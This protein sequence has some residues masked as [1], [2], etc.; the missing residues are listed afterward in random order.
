MAVRSLLWTSFSVGYRE[1]KRMLELRYFQQ[2]N[3]KK[4]FSKKKIKKQIFPKYFFYFQHTIH[5]LPFRLPIIITQHFF[6]VPQ[7]KL[8]DRVTAFIKIIIV[9]TSNHTQMHQV[10]VVFLK[11]HARHV[12][13]HLIPFRRLFFDQT[14]SHT[15]FQHDFHRFFKNEFSVWIKKA[16]KLMEC[17]QGCWEHWIIKVF[18]EDAFKRHHLD[19]VAEFWRLR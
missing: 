7:R 4:I 14:I 5:L 13:N 6:L 1:K 8:V 10:R 18:G 11:N 16:A 2:K 17:W 3:I 12:R 19:L 9:I 15:V